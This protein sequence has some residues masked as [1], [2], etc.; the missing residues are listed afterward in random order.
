MG[1][2]RGPHA[3]AKEHPLFDRIR[4][5]PAGNPEPLSCDNQFDPAGV[6]GMDSQNHGI[7]APLDEQAVC[8]ER[9]GAARAER[10][11]DGAPRGGASPG[12]GTRGDVADDGDPLI[13]LE[14]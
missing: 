12:D 11:P 10:L 3:T 2:N 1:P 4:E 5:E 8:L 7:A 13:A 9:T 14:Q 6:G